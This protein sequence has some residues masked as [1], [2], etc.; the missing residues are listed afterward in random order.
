MRSSAILLSFLC[1]LFV[2][3][4]P[5]ESVRLANYTAPPK[6][7]LLATLPI[8]F[9]GLENLPGFG[10]LENTCN[11][12]YNTYTETYLEGYE[13][14]IRDIQLRDRVINSDTLARMAYQ[15]GRLAAFHAET[16]LRQ[17]L[18]DVHFFLAQMNSIYSCFN[19]AGKNFLNSG[20]LR[21]EVCDDLVTQSFKIRKEDGKFVG[22]S[23]QAY[24]NDCEAL[25]NL[26]LQA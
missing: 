13:A 23:Y 12:N 17:P 25:A 24:F 4:Q 19:E 16:R 8:C 15:D 22:I 1:V 10:Y 9:Q 21:F 26:L 18:E 7:G 3:C 6:A 5:P 2:A 14:I 11:N 20:S